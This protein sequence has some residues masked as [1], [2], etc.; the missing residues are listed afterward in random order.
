MVEPAVVV[1]AEHELRNGGTDME[2]T[3][4]LI[5]TLLALASQV[6]LSCARGWQFE[7]FRV[8]AGPPHR[9]AGRSGPVGSRCGRRVS[10]SLARGF[11]QRDHAERGRELDDGW[12]ASFPV[13]GREIDATVLFADIT[14]FSARTADL[15]PTETLIFV[16]NFFA[17]MKN[18]SDVEI[19]EI[20]RRAGYAPM[21]S[22]DNRAHMAMEE[23]EKAGRYWPSP[24]K[25]GDQ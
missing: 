6:G 18:V 11:P 8:A 10:L 9:E 1:I 21:L 20:L 16:N 2:R 22:A 19:R 13:R 14:A 5:Q 17:W 25:P 15:T 23:I 24:P 3:Q 12:G 7:R 4:W